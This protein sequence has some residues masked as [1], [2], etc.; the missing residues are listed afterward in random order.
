MIKLFNY[1][2]LFAC[3]MSMEFYLF[4]RCWL[5]GCFALARL[6]EAALAPL[7]ALPALRVLNVSRQS[8]LICFFV[9]TCLN[10]HELSTVFCRNHVRDL[11][12]LVSVACLCLAPWVWWV[13]CWCRNS[14][15]AFA[16]AWV[17]FWNS[18]KSC[19]ESWWLPGSCAR[20]TGACIP[21]TRGVVLFS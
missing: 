2:N 6:D 20:S 21:C 9:G 3:S 14:M 17:K 15:E 10:C 12:P 4:E 1:Y 19:R 8:D 11:S 18:L 5:A 13:W 7:A 16:N